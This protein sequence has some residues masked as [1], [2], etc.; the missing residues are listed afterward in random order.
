MSLH[1][2]HWRGYGGAGTADTPTQFYRIGPKN[3]LQLWRQKGECP[4]KH[5]AAACSPLSSFSVF[6]VAVVI[7]IVVVRKR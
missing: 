1:S 7:L 5:A 3:A 4:G 6:V 2:S